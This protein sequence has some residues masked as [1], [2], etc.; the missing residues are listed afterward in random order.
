[1]LL[2]NH[3]I[4]YMNN[5]LLILAWISSLILI[6][7]CNKKQ[8]NFYTKSTEA[9]D[10]WR[11]P[12]IEPYQL[13]TSHCCDGWNFSIGS[14]FSKDFDIFGEVDSINVCK[15]NILVYMKNNWKGVYSICDVKNKTS[16]SFET[17]YDYKNYCIENDISYDLY[18]TNN[19]HSGWDKTKQLPWAK[20][21]LKRIS[22]VTPRSEE[23]LQ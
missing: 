14:E 15:E 20:E 6:I 21:I 13:L 2:C 23:C 1:M 22:S 4:E 12:I 5:K 8:T 10:I 19:I 3:R 7:S 11:I 18:L 9:R 16:T 17:F